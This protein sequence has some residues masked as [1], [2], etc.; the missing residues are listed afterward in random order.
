MGHKELFLKYLWDFSIGDFFGS[1]A[2]KESACN[3][4]DPGSIPG[5]Q[6]STGEGI[7]THCSY[8]WA[9][10]VAETVKNPPP[11]WET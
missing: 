3:A 8:S 10:L 7:A 4:G 5:L 11:M 1:S 6:R 2:R 9:S